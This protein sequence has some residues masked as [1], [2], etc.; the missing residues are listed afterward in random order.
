MLFRKGF[1]F[2]IF[3][4]VFSCMISIYASEY[5]SKAATI[6]KGARIIVY[7]EPGQA[8]FHFGDEVDTYFYITAEATGENP[9][10]NVSFESSNPSICSIEYDEEGYWVVTRLQEGISVITMSCIV[11]NEFVQRSALVSSFT[12]L[13]EELSG[14]LRTG[15]TVYYGCSSQ[16]G[17]TSNK[18][19]KEVLKE[20]RKVRVLYRCMD[21]Y[22]V[23]L[24]DGTFGDSEEEWGYL[25][26]KDVEIPVTGMTA[27]EAL[28][29]YETGK[30][31]MNIKITPEEASNQ[32][33]SYYSSNTNVA[34][35]DEKGVIT[36]SGAGSAYITAISIDNQQL[37]CKCHVTVEPY[38]AVTGI[39]VEPETLTLD[40]GAVGRIQAQVQP[41][42]A[43]IQ[44]IIW[45]VD[46]NEII[47]IDSKG[48]YK[49]KKPGTAVVT[50]ATKEKG[51]TGIC[52]ITV[53]EVAAKG[54]TIQQNISLD[55]QETK[56]L[57]WH[58]VPVNTTN[59]KVTFTSENPE[60]AVV[61]EIGQV[62]GRKVGT[63]TV[64]IVS[65][66]GAFTGSCQVHVDNY[67]KEIT[68]DEYDFHMA[69]GEKRKI[70]AEIYP[71]DVTTKAIIWESDAKQVVSVD[72][73]GNVQAKKTGLAKII[74]YD[75]YTGVYNFCMIHVEADLDTPVV[76]RKKTDDTITLKW[77]KVKYATNYRVYKYSQKKKKYQPVK[78]LKKSKRKYRVKNTKKK[79]KYKLKAYY[80][81][82]KKYSK[83]SKTIR[84]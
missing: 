14:V 38:V 76:S 1:Y 29:T 50:V 83:F 25:P 33:I 64:R 80:K 42:D 10:S 73:V 48:Y 59:K 3:T 9:V 49:A 60:I 30:V 45:S 57:A 69:L 63:T 37:V 71:A 26:I 13:E 17:I 81:P 36:G 39:T 12:E 79:S 43:T 16:E 2:T 67:V 78:W 72:K 6:G 52:K 47:T 15:K 24:I 7:D 74:V 35:V 32:G 68:L 8:R 77:K 44:D 55:I 5:I 66:E 51:F 56:Q 84:G 18:E 75:R 21:F 46:R 61:D 4:A 70:Q 40:D 23:E 53:K 31:N 82:N 19:T 11:N 65:E 58:M 20:D 41:A 22:R 27:P 28:Q 54:V 34:V 62:T